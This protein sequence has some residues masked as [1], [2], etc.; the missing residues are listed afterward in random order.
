MTLP[1]EEKIFLKTFQLHSGLPLK[2]CY[3][4]F[5]ALVATVITNYKTKDTSHLPFLGEFTFTCEG[6]TDSPK[7]A[8]TRIKT[9]FTPDS[10]FARQV[11]LI[12][13]GKQSDIEKHL[14]EKIQKNLAST[15]PNYKG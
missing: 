3:D 5:E 1:N 4:V 13:D 12:E 9:E 7:G 8:V 14:L 10:F 2:A 15:L 11:G 6:T